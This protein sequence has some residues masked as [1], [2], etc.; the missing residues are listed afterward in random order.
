[1]EENR[2][3]GRRVTI[4][5]KSQDGERNGKEKMAPRKCYDSQT[6]TPAPMDGGDG[7]GGGVR[8]G[9]GDGGVHDGSR[10]GGGGGMHDGSSGDRRCVVKCE[11]TVV[12][13]NLRHPRPQKRRV[14]AVRRVSFDGV[15]VVLMALRCWRGSQT[16]SRQ[17]RRL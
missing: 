16:P 4:K 11:V 7:R 15:V 1:M 10:C 12:L 6:R 2:G 3:G 13:A 9:D 17:R 8:D 14:N 5:N